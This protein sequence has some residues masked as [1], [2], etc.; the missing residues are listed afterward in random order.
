[1]HILE[2]FIVHIIIEYKKITQINL[3]NT[4]SYYFYR[5]SILDCANTVAYT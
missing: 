1:M 4:P 3:K 2:Y 5:K